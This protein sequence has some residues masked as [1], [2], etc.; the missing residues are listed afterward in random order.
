[1]GLFLALS[2]LSPSTSTSKKGKKRLGYE[3]GYGAVNR[4]ALLATGKTDLDNV[5]VPGM[6]EVEITKGIGLGIG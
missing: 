3:P 1:M 2:F 4:K 6:G 5:N